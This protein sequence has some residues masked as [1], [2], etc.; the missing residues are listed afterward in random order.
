MRDQDTA[1]CLSDIADSLQV[2]SQR[3]QSDSE[4]YPNVIQA[5]NYWL[6]K[7]RPFLYTVQFQGLPA[8]AANATPGT[9]NLFA[10]MDFLWISTKWIADLALAA[11]TD[12]AI[13]IPLIAMSILMASE[14]FQDSEF[15]LSQIANGPNREPLP[16][17]TPIWLPGGGTLTVNARN[18]SAATA[19]NLWLS[20]VG[21]KYKRFSSPP[22]GFQG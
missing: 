19:Y 17:P 12:S 16:L 2:L 11:I 6:V 18:Y 1:Q 8:A 5:N 10:D 22:P 15:P 14:P 13:P 4:T 9:V 21:I 7:D 20:L 3:Q